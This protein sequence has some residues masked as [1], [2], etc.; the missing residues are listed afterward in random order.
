MFIFVRNCQTVLQSGCPILHAYHGAPVASHGYQLWFSQG[1]HFSHSNRY[2]VFSPC[3]NL[4]FSSDLWCWRSCYVL[5]EP[6]FTFGVF[7]WF[8]YLFFVSLGL[9]LLRGLPLVAA[10]RGC[11]PVTVRGLLRAV[12]SLVAEHGHQ[13]SGSV[14]VAHGLHCP[15]ACG[16]FPDQGSNMCLLHW[17]ADSLPLS[18]QGTQC[19]VFITNIW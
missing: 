16:I 4:Q 18:H 17:Q 2:V 15:E 12:A 10:S 19:P 9:F 3:F 8:I 6:E 1:L 5:T 13:S 11:S 14:V 7:N